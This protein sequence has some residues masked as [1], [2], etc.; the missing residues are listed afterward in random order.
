MSSEV[1]LGEITPIQTNDEKRIYKEV[2]SH[3]YDRLSNEKLD[4]YFVE[5]IVG[6]GVSKE[7]IARFQNERDRVAKCFIE[8][9]RRHTTLCK[10]APKHLVNIA[11]RAAVRV[12]MESKKEVAE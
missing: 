5:F 4:E 11:L 10:V 1:E 9:A 12:I 2:A 3:M 8:E 7:C 6:E